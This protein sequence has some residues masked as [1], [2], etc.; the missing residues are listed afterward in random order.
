MSDM[1][2]DTVCV[3]ALYFKDSAYRKHVLEIRSE[4]KLLLPDICLIEAAYPIFEAKGGEELKKYASFVE[5]LP[6]ARNIEIIP[7]L[8]D[9]LIRALVLVSNHP[10]F[11]VEQGNLCLYDAIIATIWERTGATLVT[12]DKKLIKFGKSRGLSTLKLRKTGLR[13]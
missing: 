7:L 3:W 10:Q 9:D 2:C 13:I 8:L 1:L 6:S 4:N 12:S 11:F 5:A